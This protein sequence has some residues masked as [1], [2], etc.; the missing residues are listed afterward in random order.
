[1]QILNS[2]GNTVYTSAKL[3]N[4]FCNKGVFTTRVGQSHILFLLHPQLKKLGQMV[5]K[6]KT[7]ESDI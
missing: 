2:F 3:S 5:P 4:M 1:V 6:C 7:T